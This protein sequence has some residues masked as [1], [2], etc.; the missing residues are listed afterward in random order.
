MP[1]GVRPLPC[2]V[3]VSSYLW[4]TNRGARDLRP[5][6]HGLEIVDLIDVGNSQDLHS[7]S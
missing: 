2:I 6:R 5:W 1:S 4:G 3:R 7:R